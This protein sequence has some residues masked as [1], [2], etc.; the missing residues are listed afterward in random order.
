MFVINW[1]FGC[2]AAHASN[3]RL[4]IN[5]CTKEIDKLSGKPTFAYNILVIRTS[6]TVG[7]FNYVTVTGAVPSRVTTPNNYYSA[8]DDQLRQCMSF[9]IMS[10]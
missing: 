2:V 8:L 5:F 3:R 9:D 7:V 10:F 6:A 4:I 1:A